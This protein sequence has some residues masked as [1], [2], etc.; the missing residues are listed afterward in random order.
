MTD[1]ID[2]PLLL[3]PGP[4]TTDPR[5]RQAMTRDWGSRDK[6]F[7]AL[8]SGLRQ[9]LVE[10]VAGGDQYVCVPVQG[11]GTFAV[12]ATL[13]TLLPRDGRSLV[14]VNGAYGRRV[15]TIV[16]R[17]GRGLATYET[18]ENTPPDPAEVARLLAADPSIG[19]VVMIHCET[20][21]G[22]IN[23]L[24]EIAAVCRTAGRRLIVDAM[25]GFGVLP[26][27]AVAL[28][29]E[30]VVASSNKGLEG[31]PGVGFALIARDALAACAGRAHSLS[32]DLY[33]QWKAMEATGQ[34]RFT[35]PTHVLAGFA[36]SVDLFIAEGGQPGRAARYA[37]NCRILVEG[38]KALGFEPL[39]PAA[40]QA[41]VIVTFRMP[42]DPRFDFERFYD[43]LSARGY[44]IYPG[45]LT[46]APSFRIGCIGHLGAPEMEGA[47]A[48][49]R[50]VLSEMG[51]ASGAPS[52][53]AAA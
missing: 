4:L 5:T 2:Q 12:E 30:A 34:W 20:T 13:G 16:E 24:P 44:V 38:M 33:D 26:I 28:G 11:S 35:P 29:V 23:P 3:T 8:V 1:L 39:L 49:I 7:S 14:L 52:L 10:L 45:K 50:A 15:A 21:A 41:P 47:L 40:L 22:L 9:R 17:L 25:S 6:R 18:A 48:A 32:L 42:A 36:Q 51:V 46:V 43:Q 37:N 27:D 19:H 53:A 31:P